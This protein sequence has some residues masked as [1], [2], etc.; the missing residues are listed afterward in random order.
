LSLDALR[1]RLAQ[2]RDVIRQLNVVVLAGGGSSEREVSLISGEAVARELAGL[3]CHARLLELGPDDISISRMLQPAAPTDAAATPDAAA[4][5]AIAQ[6]E[7]G[8]AGLALFEQ[9][10]GVDMVFTTMHG[11]RGENG[12]WQGLLELLGVP[13]V[14]AGVKGSAVAMDK[15]LAKYIMERL[16]VPTPRYWLARPGLAC[17]ADVPVEVTEL[18]AKPVDQGSSVGIAMVGNDDA[19]WAEIATLTQRFGRMLVEER[20]HGRELTAGVI[21]HGDEAFALPLVEITPKRGFYDYTAKYTAGSSEYTC[22]AQV[23]ATTTALVQRHALAVYRELDLAPYARIDCLLDV[24]GQPWFLEAN[25]L[26]GFTALSLL[27]RSAKAAG[28]SFGELLELL[29]LCAIERDEA[30]RRLN[31]A[32]GA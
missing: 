11:A 25:T 15:L 12:A 3:G 9:V 14:S 7:Q 28:I 26:P 13:Y 19:G 2:R 4:L 8:G 23:S 31:D 5:E 29:M 32:Q 6:A 21:G 18:V 20:I 1:G 22:P 10:R 30:R 24:L 17:R 27:P 16:G